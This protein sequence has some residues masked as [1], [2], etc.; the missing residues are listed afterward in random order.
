[1][2]TICFGNLTKIELSRYLAFGRNIFVGILSLLLFSFFS[3]CTTGPVYVSHAPKW[4]GSVQEYNSEYIYFTGYGNGDS[5]KMA[6][7]VASENVCNVICSSLGLP[8][9]DAPGLTKD[10]RKIIVNLRKRIAK[11]AEKGSAGGGLIK[12][13]RSDKKEYLTDSDNIV[14]MYIRMKY[15]WKE[16][17]DLKN[18]LN[19]SF[20]V[21]DKEVE[22]IERM[23]Q[24][25]VSTGSYY[26]AMEL[27]SKAAFTAILN[28]RINSDVV[29]KQNIEKAG[30][31]A[32]QIKLDSRGGLPKIYTGRYNQSFLFN[33]TNRDNNR[34]VPYTRYKIVFKIKNLSGQVV[35]R[36]GNIVTESTGILNFHFPHTEYEVSTFLKFIL[37]PGFIPPSHEIPII[38]SEEITR[39]IERT[40]RNITEFKFNVI[41]DLASIPMAVVIADT[42]KIGTLLPRPVTEQSILSSFK[43]SGYNISIL[44]LD[45]GEILSRGRLE[46]ARDLTAMYGTR[47]ERIIFGKTSLVGFKQEGDLFNVTTKGEFFVVDVKKG[48]ILMSRK[49]EKRAGAIDTQKAISLSF[50]LMGRD[51]VADYIETGG[52]Q[53]IPTV[54][55]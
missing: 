43:K 39:F 2:P 29:F 55:P 36:R 26:E 51:F 49:Y 27:Y 30:A 10:Q 7:S 31:L 50:Q 8:L 45:Y 44:N 24:R 22:N 54:T 46:M 9:S 53:Q 13:L 47:F 5:M 19:K 38:Y 34:I 15:K 52:R 32:S 18:S 3:G 12:G 21:S 11:V 40:E 42:D 37:T 17:T 41:E 1:M 20:T 35:Y 48:I 16:L 4:N 33:V 23:A 28:G 25:A 6:N 14:H